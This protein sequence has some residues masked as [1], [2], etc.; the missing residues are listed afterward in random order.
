[1]KKMIL[2]ATMLLS[3]MVLLAQYKFRVIDIMPGG[4]GS[5]TAG[6]VYKDKMFMP[7]RTSGYNFELFTS[8]GTT[9]GTAVFKDLNPA[10][11]SSPANFVVC[12]GLLF[13][14]ARTD[15]A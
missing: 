5:P 14:T 8:D 1:M 6:I 11:G 4:N 7:A 9:G 12:N 2:L 13:F 15:A 10:D 3:S